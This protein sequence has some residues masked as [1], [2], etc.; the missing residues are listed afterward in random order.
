MNY[1]VKCTGY[2]RDERYFTV[3]KVYDVVDN[4]IKSDGGFLYDNKK[5]S[6]ESIIAWLSDW[7]T[8]ER[9]G[10][11]K[12]VITTDGAETLARL[13]DGNKVVKTATAKCSPADTFD[14]ATGAE[15]AFNRLMGVK[16]VKEEKKPLTFREKL[17]QERPEKVKE[18]YGGG[19]YG[20][21]S[22][23]GYE[24]KGCPKKQKKVATCSECWDREIPVTRQEPKKQEK[25]RVVNREVKAGD[26]IRLKHND[27]PEFADVGDVLKVHSVTGHL[28]KVLNN[29]MTR[30]SKK[31]IDAKWT[32]WFSEF[33]VV[34]PVTAKPFKFEVGKLYQGEDFVIEIT[35]AAKMAHDVRYCYKTIKGDA[36]HMSFFDE[37]SVFGNKLK[38]YDPPKYF[39]GKAVCVKSNKDFT[40]GKVYEFVD[41]QTTSN[42]GTKRPIGYRIEKSFDVWKERSGGLYEFLPIVE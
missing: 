7:Y 1:K 29:D 17:K 36:G 41:G 21:P 12:I 13:F 20:C 23:Y 6:P 33:E 34:E 31:H 40:V 9:V 22:S 4:T 26:Y 39:N 14:F 8:F 37:G 38:P 15:I 27:Y 25:W 11:E 28:A 16:A 24:E 10:D 32:Y 35:E 5:G 18:V 2:K 30:P 19:C 42:G 3:G